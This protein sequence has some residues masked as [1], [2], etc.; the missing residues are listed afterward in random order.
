MKFKAEF[1]MGNAAFED[2][3][4]EVS[5]LLREIADKTAFWTFA[6]EPKSGQ[7]KDINGTKIGQ[8]SIEN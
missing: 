4:N 8:W 1:D 7:I 6:K 5:R 2:Y 3:P